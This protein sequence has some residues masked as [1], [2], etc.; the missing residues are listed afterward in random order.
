MCNPIL[1]RLASAFITL[2]YIYAIL[3][4]QLFGK[5]TMFLKIRMT[6]N[7][8]LL[9]LW[10]SKHI[11]RLYL[12]SQVDEMVP[13]MEV[14]AHAEGARK[15]W[16]DVRMERFRGSAHVAHARTDLERYWGMVKK[17]WEDVTSPPAEAP[18]QERAVCI[19]NLHS[20]L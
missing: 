9:L 12:Y 5:K 4:Y 2:S 1:Q 13:W 11:P 8:Y 17:V 19:G 10:F 20:F 6:L 18:E 15:A 14:E 16:L 7:K 3:A